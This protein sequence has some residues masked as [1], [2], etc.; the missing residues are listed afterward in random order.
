MAKR[1][2]QASL[3]GIKQAKQA[4]ASKG[5]TQAD[6][7]REIGIKTRQ[8][9][10]RFFAGQPVDRQVFI[11][12][13]FLL[14]LNWQEI[15]EITNGAVT[16][17]EGI[18]LDNV[19]ALVER[20][21]SQYGEK[22]EHQCGTLRLLDVAY[23]VNLEDIYVEVKILEQPIPRKWLELSDWLS[24][25]EKRLPER[26]SALE[27]VA[28]YNKLI[29]LGK[30]GSGK[31]TFLQYLARACQRGE[32]QDSLVPIF[33]RLKDFGEDTSNGISL[34]EYISQ[35]LEIC[36]IGAKEVEKLLESG[37]MLILL[38]GLDEVR[39][40]DRDALGQEIRAFS[41]RYYK[42]KYAIATRT[43]ACNYQLENFVEVEIADFNTQ[44]I[45]VF[46]KKWFV[47]VPK[48]NQQEGI[49]KASAFIEKLNLEGDLIRELAATPLLLHLLC[50]AFDA[51]VKFP[52]QRS[53][54]YREALDIMLCRWDAVRGIQRDETAPNLSLAGKIKL[55]SYLAAIAFERG[56]C[57]FEIAK[58][59]PDIAEYLRQLPDADTDPE[60]LE[61]ASLALVKSIE[62]KHGL[63]VWRSHNMYAFSHQ[64]FLVYLTA[65]QIAN[66][67][68]T[69]GAG[70]TN[71]SL[72][73]GNISLNPPLQ[74]TFSTNITDKRWHSVFLT[75]VEILP[76]AA[77]LLQIMKQQID[78]L[79]A[80]DETLQHFL[81]WVIQKSWSFQ[82]NPKIA[83]VR[84]FYFSLACVLDSYL[85]FA[86]NTTNLEIKFPP[87]PDFPL[88]LD[89]NFA[90]KLDSNLALTPN[91]NFAIEFEREL[92]TPDDKIYPALKR[93]WELELILSCVLNFDLARKRDLALELQ[94]SL[95]QLK[96]KLPQ[97]AE[98]SESFQTWWQGNG[99]TWIE[100]LKALL[101]AHHHAGHHWQFSHQQK[102]LLKQ[103]YDANQLLVD[104]LNSGCEVTEGV[105]QQIEET[106][107]LVIG[108]CS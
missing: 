92:R 63:L 94:N 26:V 24:N 6:L 90:Q 39:Q 100:E 56:D 72:E 48:N 51:K 17:E 36:G 20:A 57:V 44:Q 2:F 58:I 60:A 96:A 98:N 33:M 1:S 84:A 80:K 87:L 74:A 61:V 18:S 70:F 14:G 104:C 7:A 31:T 88:P 40:K 91:F 107:L 23:P 99:Q 43:A 41:Q 62:E 76:N 37:R 64:T 54:I 3:E 5:W 105:R 103:Y 55:L 28:K 4:F 38:D 35:E 34:L 32:L 42:N 52:R 12:L 102:Q 71:Q 82:E 97:E 95:Q 89:L 29:L 25:S 66:A 106:L 73:P 21:R 16:D 85:D 65:K 69:V 19:D 108:N 47:T 75:L 77:P 79:L 15:A 78:G 49:A 86:L 53:K 30:P 45:A 67:G 11:E 101:I 22:I 93:L 9:I 68:L 50:L 27:A 46:A 59:Q 81:K 83:A 13:C 10:G 8:P